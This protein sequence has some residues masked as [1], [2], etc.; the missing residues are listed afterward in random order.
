VH[1]GP[2]DFVVWIESKR[3]LLDDI[4]KAQATSNPLI[5]ATTTLEQLRPDKKWLIRATD[6]IATC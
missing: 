2:G 3:D 5:F 1:F 4:L 6:A